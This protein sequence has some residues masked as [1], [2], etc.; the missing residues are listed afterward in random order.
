MLSD[1]QMGR[2]QLLASFSLFLASSDVAYIRLVQIVELAQ[3]GLKM[4]INY[5]SE[6]L[7]MFQNEPRFPILW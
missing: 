5:H 4:E 6:F 1:V 7:L 2:L 3:N